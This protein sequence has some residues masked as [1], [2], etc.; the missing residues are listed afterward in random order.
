MSR[1]V[2]D[3]V[4]SDVRKRVGSAKDFVFIDASKMDAF[5]Q[6]TLRLTLREQGI[7]I[8]G[9]KNTLASKVLKENGVSN[10]DHLLAGPTSLVFGASDIVALSK[11]V[12]KQVK[13][14]K[15]KLE[16]KGGSVEG[17][18][19]DAKQLEAVSK[20]PSREE[21]IGKIVGLMLS[22]GANLAAAL[23]GPGGT[24][25]GQVKSK[26]EED[27]EASG[28]ETKEAAATE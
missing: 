12:F 20:G 8:V 18:G 26:S 3:L 11:E 1:A 19:L 15:E 13:S 2:K 22:P 21:L 14:S 24:L 16:V 23:L 9:V 5:S 6:N 27:G 28:G 7:R 17:S 25:V 4:I 10:V